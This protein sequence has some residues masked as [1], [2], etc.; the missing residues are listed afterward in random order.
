MS[1]LMRGGGGGG[2]SAA[3]GAARDPGIVAEDVE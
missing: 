1:S 3:V 2:G